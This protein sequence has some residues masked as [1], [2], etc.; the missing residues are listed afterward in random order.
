VTEINDAHRRQL[1]EKTNEARTLRTAI[2]TRDM[3]LNEYNARLEEVTASHR[4]VLSERES[5]IGSL[6]KRLSAHESGR[7]ELEAQLG[8]LRGSLL[9]IKREHAEAA[10]A[11]RE[12]ISNYETETNRWEVAHQRELMSANTAHA[13]ALERAEAS[14]RETVDAQEAEIDRMRVAVASAEKRANET[15]AEMAERTNRNRLDVARMRTTMTERHDEALRNALLEAERRRE[16]VAASATATF[17]QELSARVEETR[18]RLENEHVAPKVQEVAQLSTE[19]RV[20]NERVQSLESEIEAMS[21]RF[22]TT[23][24]RAREDYEAEILNLETQCSKQ[25]SELRDA[26]SKCSGDGDLHAQALDML[27]KVLVAEHAEAVESLKSRHA[28]QIARAESDHASALD[29]IRDAS[30]LTSEA[31]ASL[32]REVD[33]ANREIQE[34]RDRISTMQIERPKF[35]E[36]ELR[37][38]REELGKERAAALEAA[39]TIHSDEM[40]ASL[41]RLRTTLQTEYASKLKHASEESYE[42]GV[43]EC[44]RE[45]VSEINTERDRHR[46]EANKKAEF[47]DKIA[48]LEAKLREAEEDGKLSRLRVEEE[49][50]RSKALSEA[51]AACREIEKEQRQ[52]A[53]MA[54]RARETAE[55]RLEEQ[56]AAVAADLSSKA[57]DDVFGS[58]TED[59]VPRRSEEDAE[60][61]AK[62]R[63]DL[64]AER[65]KTKRVE[66]DLVRACASAAAYQTKLS[67]YESASGSN[68]SGSTGGLNRATP[69]KKATKPSSTSP[70]NEKA[71]PASVPT[72][73]SSSGWGIS[74]LWAGAT[75]AT[76]TAAK[77][78]PPSTSSPST[79]PPETSVPIDVLFGKGSL[80]FELKTLPDN[81]GTYV[82]RLTRPSLLG[83]TSWATKYNQY[84]QKKVG[85]PKRMLRAG[86]RP[87]KVNGAPLPK[88]ATKVA[89]VL[90]TTARPMKIHFLPALKK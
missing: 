68:L 48:D 26:I 21:E 10:V 75:S 30:S 52:K 53:T 73:K 72:T 87:I 12:R 4:R 56:E 83:D 27:R 66:E 76:T 28:M 63:A 86:M 46:H 41:D 44:R 18:R 40:S 5:S 62:L 79:A 61:V 55:R 23:T 71:S 38:V 20:T 15:A 50:K 13:Q 57:L 8:T 70:A 34:C 64:A 37:G 45:F 69:T 51:L 24:R 88:T 22:D 14:R 89:E 36:T 2:D 60:M 59:V 78:P 7:A 11:A 84:I 16:D 74:S 77:D 9:D 65:A 67:R 39:S 35:L 43:A 82:S 19:L 17:R 81:S 1:D 90:K 6:T 58:S 3:R 85:D 29:R 33:E 25:S 54:T 32:S 47:T 49:S 80:G 42:D 31:N